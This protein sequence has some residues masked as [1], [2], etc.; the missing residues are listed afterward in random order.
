MPKILFLVDVPAP[1]PGETST[2]PSPASV[3]W[4]RFESDIA[5][6]KIGTKG[7]V[8]GLRNAW[9][10]D[11]EHSLDTLLLLKGLVSAHDLEY[12]SFWVPDGIVELT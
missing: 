9:L 12:R 7:R 2:S 4:H 3:A 11:A 8:K 1:K 6:N 10:I 5:A